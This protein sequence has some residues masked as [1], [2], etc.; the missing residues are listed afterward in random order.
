MKLKALFVAVGA[1][2]L[3]F[4]GLQ[5][6]ADSEIA[7]SMRYLL[8]EGVSHAQ[9]YL[10]REDGKLLRQLTHEK[11]GQV[12]SPVFAPDGATIVFEGVKGKKTEY[13]SVEPRGGNLRKLD[14]APGWYFA[15]KDSPYFTNVEPIP[16]GAVKVF[17]AKID[18]ADGKYTT[19]DGKQEL[20]LE[21]PADDPDSDIDFEG[22]GKHYLL[23]DLKTKE[24][25]EL[26]KVQ[27]FLGLYE[28]LHTNGKNDDLFLM[29]QSLRLAFFGLHLNSS[30]GDTV[31]ALDLNSPRLVRLSP[32]WATPVPLP[33][34][35]AFLTLNEARYQ[36]IP[37]S[38]KTANG[39]YLAHWDSSLKQVRYGRDDTATDCYGASMYRPGMK[40][41]VIT[42]AGPNSDE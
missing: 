4:S 25:V 40:P 8:A 24:S 37:G 27:G 26:G 14:A 6:R 10:F 15:A 22:H 2:G 16:A 18:D 7:V 3:T 30:D 23:R 20:I 39:S 33:G 9:L 11:S 12:C 35:G 29:D 42:V 36:P 1:M 32:N 28:L 17:G 31:F 13:W 38:E 5:A 19:P 21:S 41:T 34:E